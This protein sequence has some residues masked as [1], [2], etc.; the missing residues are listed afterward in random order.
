LPLRRAL[1]STRRDKKLSQAQLGRFVGLS[2]AHIS[3]IESGQIVPRYDTLLEL[4]R[5]LDHDLLLVPR[6]LGPMVD[7]L[8]RERRHGASSEEEGPLYEV[9]GDETEDDETTVDALSAN[10]QSRAG[11]RVP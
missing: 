6:Q 10:S 9:E 5:V 11:K 2:Q 8:L 7:A 4:V 1:T 3:G